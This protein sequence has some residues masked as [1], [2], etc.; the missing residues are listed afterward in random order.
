MAVNICRDC[1]F[2]EEIRI[3]NRGNCHR[4]PTVLDTVSSHW[5]GEFQRRE[6]EEIK[7]PDYAAIGLSL[8]DRK[9][10]KAKKNV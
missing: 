10:T 6:S 3:R 2:W 5:C 9:S 4:Y 8:E 7:E 1:V